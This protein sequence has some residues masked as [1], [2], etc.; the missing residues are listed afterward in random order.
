MVQFTLIRIS[1]A[2]C[3]DIWTLKH[4]WELFPLEGSPN[5]DTPCCPPQVCSTGHE[6]RLSHHRALG[7]HDNWGRLFVSHWF[8]KSPQRVFQPGACSIHHSATS[9]LHLKLS[10]VA[11]I[12]WHRHPYLFS[13]KFIIYDTS[14]FLPLGIWIL[15]SRWSDIWLGSFYLSCSFEVSSL[16]VLLYSLY[17]V[18]SSSRGDIL[19]AWT[20]TSYSS[21][22]MAAVNLLLKVNALGRWS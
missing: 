13:W 7:Q 11:I 14:S 15:L 17:D 16:Q 5:L 21:L 8:C 3:S 20:N 22:K 4:S 10:A 12:A 2:S 9:Q 6:L 18:S 19:Q 1:V